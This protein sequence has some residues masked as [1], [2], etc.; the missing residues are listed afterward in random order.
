MWAPGDIQFDDIDYDA[1]DH[2][3]A[4]IRMATPVGVVE[5][6]LKSLGMGARCRC[7]DY[8]SNQPLSPTL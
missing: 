7:G 1:T 6:M 4:T 8:M 3:V 2:P 5:L